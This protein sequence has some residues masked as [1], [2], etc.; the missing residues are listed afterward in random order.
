MFSEVTKRERIHAGFWNKTF[1]LF[2]FQFY[3]KPIYM[4]EKMLPVRFFVCP[5][6]SEKIGSKELE[7]LIEG[8][9]NDGSEVSFIIS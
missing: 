9:I 2:L 1:S 3:F 4:E 6:T 8:Y 5:G 7:M